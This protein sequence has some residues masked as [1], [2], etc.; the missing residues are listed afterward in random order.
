MRSSYSTPSE[1]ALLLPEG[2]IT[3]T[4]THSDLS[5]TPREMRLFRPWQPSTEN[6]AESTATSNKLICCCL[7]LTSLFIAALFGLTSLLHSALCSDATNSTCPTN[8]PRRLI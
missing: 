8:P 5:P 4:P 2:A 3:T 7:L 1:A 6:T